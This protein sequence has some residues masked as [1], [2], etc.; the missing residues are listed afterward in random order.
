MKIVLR[1][2]TVT[3]VYLFLP[4]LSVSA[5]GDGEATFQ[6]TCSACH[7]VGGGRLVGPDLVDIQSRRS[8]EWIKSFIKSS[9]TVIKSGDKY[10]DSLFKAYS[11]MPMPDHP[12]L[13]D[14]QIAGI[15]AYIS[16]KSSAPATTA[17]VSSVA[18]TGDSQRGG[19][20]FSGKMRFTNLGASCNSCHNV[21]MDGFISGGALA[22]DLTHS[23]TRLTAAGVEGVISGL[24]F[25]QMKETYNAKPITPQE[26]AD[27][28][29]FLTT[30]DEQA[31]DQ[32]T[33]SIGNYLITGGIVGII[34]LLILY[35]LFWIR[36]KNRTVNQA[37]Y[38]RQIKS[39]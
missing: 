8:D 14:E 16:D 29:A 22:K 5:Q 3:A 31:P 10:A 36:R 17:V 37:I 1:F 32:V 38:K 4:F 13:T 15:I 25:P 12:S 9:Q 2:F 7:T 18:L 6:Q 34:A 19:E 35:S 23:I 11:E 24:P 39:I 30:A 28:T 20:L 21:S 26:I 33:S 27:L